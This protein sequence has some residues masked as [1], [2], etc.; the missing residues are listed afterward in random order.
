MLRDGRS[1]TLV[2]RPGEGRLLRGDEQVPLTLTEFR[3]LCELAEAHGQVLSRRQLL[4][5]VWA[6]GFFGDERL[7]DVH[8]RRLRIKVEP[9]PS[10]PRFVVMVRGLGYRLE[11]H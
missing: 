3:L 5:R 7:V 11:T 10:N 1:G 8:I 9:E 6:H 2:L 4:E